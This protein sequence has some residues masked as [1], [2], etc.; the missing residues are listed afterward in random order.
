MSAISATIRILPA[1]LANQIA[2][3]EVVERPASVVKELVENSLDSG[4]SQIDIEIDKGG[5]KRIC[6]RDNGGGIEKDQLALAL[7]RHATSK[8][9]SL[10]DLE[11]IHS[12]GFRG[13]ALAS[14]SSVARLTLT[15][16]P[17]LQQQA[18]QAHA[19]GRDMQVQLNPVAHPDGSS[20]EVI[21]LF[22]NTPA[23]R[24]FLRAEKTE[25]NHID[26]VIRRISLSRFDVSFSLKHNG[27]LLRKYPALT[28]QTDHLKRLAA[29]CNKDFAHSAIAL[30]SHYQ[31]MQLTGWIAPPE[32]ADRQSDVQYFY[33]NDRMMRDKLINHAIRQAF[34]G[35][36]NPETSPNYVLY[37]HIPHHEVDVN[38]HPAKHEVRFHQARL[39]HDFIFRAISD[40]INQYFSSGAVQDG[41]SEL[42]E[43]P[44]QHNYITPLQ[45]SST[46]PSEN[47]S[48]EAQDQSS[49]QFVREPLTSNHVQVNEINEFNRSSASD[50]QGRTI[51]T[52]DEQ[53]YL[54]SG[55]MAH[56]GGT[57]RASNRSFA[58]GKSTKSSNNLSA[59]ALI[60]YQ[61]L[62]SSSVDL[63]TASPNS[64]DHISLCVPLDDKSVLIFYNERHY[65]VGINTLLEAHIALSFDEKNA[66][67]QPLLM[68]VSITA[69]KSI[70]ARAQSIYEPLLNNRV[71]IGWSQKRIILRKVPSGMR[72]LPWANILPALFDESFSDEQ[73]L[74]EHLFRC[75][76]L[77]S[78][79][80]TPLQVQQVWSELCV[81]PQA[82][83]SLIN[84][85]VTLPLAKLISAHVEQKH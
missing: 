69:D 75:I 72:H 81:V 77:Y 66:I 48:I 12:L 62:M 82:L 15:S 63:D 33:V 49:H 18:W 37:L 54:P 20:V 74:R 10:D 57:Q 40:G 7:S 43:V 79:K 52:Q 21:D 41:P 23:R 80:L 65:F 38:V 3:G 64:L 61:Q 19:E 50:S 17:K 31:E 60:G 36:I 9:S 85:A 45:G 83:D 68:P 58:P 70:L 6:I 13:E 67:T 46:G 42:A 84:V 32:M 30:D 76:A 16:K 35:A 29:I 73:Q 8:I 53:S 5:H 59:Q 47:A 44:P 71:D 51:K 25:F 4:A 39:V 26:E 56:H 28:V 24:K 27:K 11:H 2:A 78:P 14:I 22:F 1:Q 34:E 55:T